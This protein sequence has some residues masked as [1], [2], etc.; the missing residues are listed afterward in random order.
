MCLDYQ[1][2]ESTAA[3]TNQLTPE[4]LKHLDTFKDNTSL[5]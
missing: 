3:V 2:F 1:I 4:H 5:T